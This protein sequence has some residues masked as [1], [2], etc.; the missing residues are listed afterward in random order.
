MIVVE[1]QAI[2]LQMTKRQRFPLR[3]IEE[4]PKYLFGEVNSQLTNRNK[5]LA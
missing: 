2:S 1:A 4:T 3:V 5:M